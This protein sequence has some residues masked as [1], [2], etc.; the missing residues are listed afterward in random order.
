M[1]PFF[2]KS[3]LFQRQNY[4]LKGFDLQSMKFGYDLFKPVPNY[5]CGGSPPAFSKGI[6]V[7]RFEGET[8]YIRGW[9]INFAL[10]RWTG[11]CAL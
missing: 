3:N 4:A 2:L 10:Y 11:A 5:E 9:H 7:S 8:V 1:L 6:V